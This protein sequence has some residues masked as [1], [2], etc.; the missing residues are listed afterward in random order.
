MNILILSYN[1]HPEPI[2]IAPLVTELAEGLLHR[3]HHVQVVTAFPN[4]PQRRIYDG[5][6]RKLFHT[7]I[8]NGVHLVRHWVFIRPQPGL[9]TRIAFEVTTL[10]FSTWASLR[11][12]KTKPDV[13]LTISPQLSGSLTARL[14][15]LRLGIPFIL[16]IQ[17]LLP[18]A[19]IASGILKNS[20]LISISRALERFAYHYAQGITVI[21]DQFVHNLTSKGVSPTK[22]FKIP[23]WVDTSFIIPLNRN[24]V[25][26]KRLGLTDAFI[27]MYSGN[28]ALTQSLETLVDCANL[29]RDDPKIQFVIVGE[30]CALK[31]LN[32]YINHYKLTNVHRLP[33]QP[34]HLLPEMLASADVSVILQK[35]H[36]VDINMPSKTMLLMASKRPVIASVN[37]QGEVAKI[38]R[39]SG[40]GIVV[41]PE[42]PAQL[43]ASLLA[44][45]N[46]PRQCELL[47]ERGRAF[48]CEHFEREKALIA[49]EQILLAAQNNKQFPKRPA[50]RS[51]AGRFRG[52]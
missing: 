48:A 18:D 16:N 42:K 40:C 45:K 19:A 47:G 13:I 50:R 5:Y 24:T 23:N 3:G 22:L 20:F 51:L 12:T 26:R 37:A 35:A 41:S 27:V 15:S 2:G 4:Y 8:H 14:L 38:I 43:A 28:I 6:K 29:L 25:L 7:E 34:R 44:L 39:E 1:Y 52:L 17:D 10:L 30:D 46:D 9:W 21:S 31:S 36:I 11:Q 33:F 32:K 49:Y